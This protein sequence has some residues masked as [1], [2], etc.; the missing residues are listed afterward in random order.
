MGEYYSWYASN[1]I[2]IKPPTKQKT[3]T[4]KIKQSNKKPKPHQANNQP[5]Q[6]QQTPPLSPLVLLRGN[7]VR[8]YVLAI[9]PEM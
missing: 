7:S 3:L 2:N 4:K 9:L 1:K 8:S 6:Q 5:T